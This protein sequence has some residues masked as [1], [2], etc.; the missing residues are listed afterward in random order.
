MRG[1]SSRLLVRPLS[2]L[3]AELSD[4]LPLG[5]DDDGSGSMCILEAYR[6][7]LAADFRPSR[8]IEFQWYAAEVPTS[9][10]ALPG[11]RADPRR[12]VGGWS[13]RISGDCA[14]V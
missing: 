1:P 8:T 11:S 12:P 2:H 7:L 14:S 5:A 9:R 13:A 4:R 10:S 6:A 3:L